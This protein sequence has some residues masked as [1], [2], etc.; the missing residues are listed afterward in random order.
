MAHALQLKIKLSLLYGNIQTAT[1]QWCDYLAFTKFKQKGNYI[2]I[3]DFLIGGPIQKELEDKED[4][5]N[6]DNGFMAWNLKP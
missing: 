2:F 1:K 4:L 6:I 5:I 3:S